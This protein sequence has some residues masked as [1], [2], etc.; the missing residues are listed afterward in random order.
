[1]CACGS[2]RLSFQE[3]VPSFHPVTKLRSQNQVPSLLSHRNGVRVFFFFPFFFPPFFSYLSLPLRRDSVR[4]PGCPGTHY[5]DQ[6]GFKLRFTCPCLCVHLCL[7]EMYAC[8]V[9]TCM[10]SSKVNTGSPPSG[11]LNPQ[12]IGLAS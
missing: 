5:V 10:W 8:V 11:A 4:G 12:L 9:C 7:C 1:M 6:V 3:L 2:Q